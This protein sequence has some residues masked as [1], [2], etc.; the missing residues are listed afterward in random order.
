[1]QEISWIELVKGAAIE[2]SASD[3]ETP[4]SAYFNAPQSFA[5]SPH[6]P[7]SVLQKVWRLATRVALSSGDILAYIYAF[8]KTLY[9]IAYYL[10]S[11]TIILKALPVIARA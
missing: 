9:R 3:K 7:T 10:G 2:A 8:N 1:M 5:P 11:E 4:T 6:I